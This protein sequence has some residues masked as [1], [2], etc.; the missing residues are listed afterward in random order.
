MKKKRKTYPESFRKDAVNFLFSS[1]KSVA[2][3]ADE[4]G[5]ELYNLSRWKKQYSPMSTKSDSKQ[6]TPAEK[7]KRL[8]SQVKRLEKENSTLIQEREILKKA[9][10]I[11][12]KQ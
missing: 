9:M 6:E 5:I 11:V 1:G 4:L 12:S 8:E 7:L 10:G 2:E 3:V